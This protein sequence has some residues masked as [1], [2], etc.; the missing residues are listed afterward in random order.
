[1]KEESRSGNKEDKEKRGEGRKENRGRNREGNRERNRERNREGINRNQQK[2][3]LLEGDIRKELIWLAVPLLA[4]NILQQCYNIADSLI[5]GRFLGMKAFAAAGVAGTVMNLMIFVMNGFTTGL[6]VVF[7]SFY[8]AGDKERF[9]QEVFVA[10]VA[11]GL[12]TGVI[13]GGFLAEMDWI[14]RLIRTPEELTENV[15]SY[16]QIIAGG[17]IAVYFYNLF[18]GIF[19]AVGNA[20]AGLCF[21]L[22]S[23]SGNIVMDL[24]FVE[25]LGWGMRGAALAT[26]LA[27][28]AGAAACLGYLW[29]WYR[30]L[31]CTRRDMGIHW[32]LMRKTFRFGF[33]SALQE[34]SLYIGKMF[35]QGAVNLLGTSGIAAY[36]AA[37]RLEG[38]ANSFGDSGALALSVMIS[39]N[40]GA[41]DKERVRESFKEGVRLHVLLGI[42]IPMFMFLAAGPGLSLFLNSGDK[43]ALGEGYA[44]LRIISMLYILCFVGSALV[45]FFRGIGWVHVPVIGTTLNISIRI[46]LAGPATRQYGLAGLAAVTGVGWLAVVSYQWM[47]LLRIRGQKRTA[48]SLDC[49]KCHCLK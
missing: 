4:G 39:Q 30:E 26:V 31:L 25:G 43:T 35:V 34:S 17:M 21:L 18:S 33:A 36:T 8:G 5:I 27:Q 37:L 2:N 20:T 9:R 13:S 48:S 16:L 1:M 49:D 24:W 47:N 32:D 23:V 40:H 46:I 44:Y 11:G 41:G 45:G 14:L 6:S 12:L 15:K 7:A 28:G 19:R 3:C 22:I 42:V 29:Y 38:F 10:I